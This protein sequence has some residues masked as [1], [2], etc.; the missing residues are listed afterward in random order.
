MI[1]RV[2]RRLTLKSGAGVIAASSVFSWLFV[3]HSGVAGLLLMTSLSGLLL[4]ILVRFLCNW[5]DA[6]EDI[7]RVL[8]W[9]MA[10]FAVH[11]VIGLII[12][13]SFSLTTYLGGDAIQYHLGAA[14]IFR[15]WRDGDPITEQIPRGKEGFYYLLAAQYWFFGAVMRVGLPLNAAMASAVIPLLSD[16]TR[17]IFG[18]EALRYVPPLLLL[19]PGFLL[20]PSEL[21][22][23][24]GIMF[25]M[26]VALNAAA[27]LVLR[28]RIISVVM[29][30]GALG[31]LMTFRSYVA[32]M[33]GAGLVLGITLGR[34]GLGGITT[35]I[36]SL[37]L[38]LALV[39]G[40]GVGY[41]GFKVVTTTDTHYANNIRQDSSQTSKSGY[42]QEAPDISTA[43]GALSYLP[44]AYPY[45]AFGPFP[46]QAL[47][48]RQLPAIPDA[49]AWWF[50][51]PSLFTGIKIARR[52]RDRRV[53]LF[54]VPSLLLSVI[55]ALLVANFGTAVRLRMQVILL[56]VPVIAA[57]LAHRRKE[58]HLRPLRHPEMARFQR[59][60]HQAEGIPA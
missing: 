24:A 26:A 36:S 5:D 7:D 51:L 10:A 34:R 6:P 11:L 28:T 2:R 30:I 4:I 3:Q 48:P 29:M 22:R 12:S 42:L 16:L 21:L 19:L 57:G 60:P 31:L 43:H 53:L 27:R 58:A 35:G 47:S 46:W 20:W 54:L 1:S 15:H 38:V 32:F 14:N 39:V 17:R 18:R 37:A 55:L 13:S 44:L 56:L 23:E 50:L 59:P 45:F 52:G 8:K 33:L 40:L 49:V 25:L 41:S 9:T